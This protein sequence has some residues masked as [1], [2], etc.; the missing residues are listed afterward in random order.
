MFRARG[1][2]PGSTC[3]VRHTQRYREDIVPNFSAGL[4][5]GGGGAVST[6]LYD[7]KALHW[8]WSR[9]TRSS[10]LNFTLLLKT[11]TLKSPYWYSLWGSG[12]SLKVQHYAHS[13]LFRPLYSG[14]SSCSEA[15]RLAA[16]AKVKPLTTK[17]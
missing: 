1:G 12:W 13:L 16:L 3:R 14:K 17:N 10:D 7:V 2:G 6:S 4:S 15:G 5:S 8:G 11:L 9:S